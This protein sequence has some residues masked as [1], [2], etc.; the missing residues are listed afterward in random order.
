MRKEDFNKLSVI[1]Y[2][3]SGCTTCLC[4]ISYLT[5]YIM[6]QAKVPFYN[7]GILQDNILLLIKRLFLLFPFNCIIA[8]IIVIFSKRI[9]LNAWI[10]WKMLSAMLDLKN[11][12]TAHANSLNTASPKVSAHTSIWLIQRG[13][14]L[15]NVGQ[16]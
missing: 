3:F 15:T 5:T 16:T 9:R 11:M 12:S 6:E 8:D 2:H 14:K 1:F 7:F 10:S 13:Q 4:V